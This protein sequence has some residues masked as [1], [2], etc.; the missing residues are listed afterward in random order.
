[1]RRLLPADE[2]PCP[3]PETPPG[4]PAKEETIAS[5]SGPRVSGTAPR[6]SSPRP[7][8]SRRWAIRPSSARGDVAGVPGPAAREVRKEPS[9]RRVRRWKGLPIAAT[10]SEPPGHPAQHTRA[11][12]L[13]LHVEAAAYLSRSPSTQGKMKGLPSCSQAVWVQI[14]QDRKRVTDRADLQP[15]DAPYRMPQQVPETALASSVLSAE[16]DRLPP[17]GQRR[18]A[19]ASLS[20]PDQERWKPAE[21]CGRTPVRPADRRSN[22]K[23]LP[24]LQK[25]DHRGS[26]RL[27]SARD[28]RW[29]PVTIEHRLRAG[30]WGST[31]RRLLG[32]RVCGSVDQQA[33][34]RTR[35]ATRTAPCQATDPIAAL[36]SGCPGFF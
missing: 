21:R 20:S 5:H 23:Q 25:K 32:N 14:R 13:P 15:R 3:G 17:A 7:M 11:A 34:L 18:G 28:H 27:R 16:S 1:L 36:I 10:S 8:V 4:S 6:L 29:R 9:E 26:F 19:R 2:A 33:R 22:R 35:V 30:V 24:L 12:G 31:R